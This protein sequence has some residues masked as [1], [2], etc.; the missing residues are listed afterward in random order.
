M[1]KKT[2]KYDKEG[3]SQLPNNMP[4]LYRIKNSKGN[5]NYVGVARRSNV[6]DRISDHL[7]R[8]PG[9]KIEIEQFRSI[10]DAKKKEANV[11]KRNKP[12]YNKL[13]K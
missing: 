5:D 9:T 2:V 12:K 6:R 3:I 7:G 1:A 10:K 11:I 13:G 4:A 8:I